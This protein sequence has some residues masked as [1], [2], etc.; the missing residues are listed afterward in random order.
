MRLFVTGTAGFIGFHLAKALL[1]NGHEVHGYDSVNDYYDPAIKEA[2]LA[3][4]RDYG[5]FGFTRGLLE[6][7]AVLAG[8][9]EKF[10][11]DHAV[12]LAAQAGV[13]YSLVNP[14]AYIQSNLIG[15]QNIIELARSHKLNHFVYASSSSVYGGTTEYPFVETQRTDNPISLYA[16]TKISNEMV[17]KAYSHLY[18][19]P[20]TG[21][22]FFTVYGPNDR[23]NMAIFKFT[24]MI[25]DDEPIPVFNN[26]EMVRDFTFIDD[27]VQGVLASIAL[28]EMG[29]IYNLGRGRP[30]RL[31]DVIGLIENCLGKKARYDMM[32]MQDGDVPQTYADISKASKFLNFNPTTNVE[33]GI[34]EFVD[35]FRTR[36][37]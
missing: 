22:R 9:W 6:D 27:I 18:G 15:F 19:L 36:A 23:P 37:I 3:V 33:E 4:L 2:R 31:M 30:E 20:S 24:R 32:P 14:A 21:L 29:Q 12:H 16:A 34:P 11:P 35:W 7:N 13:R 28:P 5:R 26:G 17:A 1:E 10:S 25:T 8:A